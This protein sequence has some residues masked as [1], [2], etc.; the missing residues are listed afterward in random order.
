MTFGEDK[1]ADRG[2]IFSLH[3]RDSMGGKNQFMLGELIKVMPS[4]NGANEANCAE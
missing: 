2:E 4:A 1:T 3:H